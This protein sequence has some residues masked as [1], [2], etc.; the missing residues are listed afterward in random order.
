MMDRNFDN[1]MEELERDLEKSSHA[2]YNIEETKIQKAVGIILG[3]LKSEV[4]GL[5]EKIGQFNETSS[6]LQRALIWWTAFIAI[7]TILNIFF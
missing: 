6:R 3:S 5:N 7:A 1:A 2:P 4:G